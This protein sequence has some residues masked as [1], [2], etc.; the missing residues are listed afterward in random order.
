MQI[1]VKKMIE[2]ELNEKKVNQSKDFDDGYNEGYKFACE[3]LK[4]VIETSKLTLLEIL[5]A[6]IKIREMNK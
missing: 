4:E 2:N 1:G 5:D 6:M 3:Q